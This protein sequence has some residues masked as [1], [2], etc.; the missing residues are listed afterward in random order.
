MVVSDEFSHVEIW[1]PTAGVI[2]DTLSVSGILLTDT[3]GQL[4]FTLLQRDG[5]M[6]DK[7]LISPRI[8][9]LYPNNDLAKTCGFSS[10]FIPY[11]KGDVL[12]LLLESDSGN[13]SLVAEFK[14]QRV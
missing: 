1:E 14:H 10:D 11:K 9:K 2:E 13:K 12:R 4:S 6:V 5:V 7:N 8:G 3:K